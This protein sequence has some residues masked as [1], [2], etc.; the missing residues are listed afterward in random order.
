FVIDTAISLLFFFLSSF[1]VI[2]SLTKSFNLKREQDPLYDLHELS[3][4]FHLTLSHFVM[5]GGGLAVL[6]FV[7]LLNVIIP[8]PIEPNRTFLYSILLMGSL[9][10]FCI[11]ITVVNYRV[12]TRKFRRIMKFFYGL[13]F[14]INVVSY[15]IFNP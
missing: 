3:E 4:Y 9:V 11:Y 7:S 2:H 1:V 15:L 10:G 12:A 6:L 13:G 8:L 14:S 5:F